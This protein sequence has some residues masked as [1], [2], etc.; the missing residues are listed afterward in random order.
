MRQLISLLLFILLSTTVFSQKITRD[1]YIR[2]WQLVAIE[3]MNR[4][5]IPASITMAQGCLESGNGNSELSR[6]SNNHFGIKCKSSWKGK[7]VY[8]DDDRRNE[9]FRSY[10]SVKD[11]YEDHTDFLMNNPRYASLFLLDHTDY[12]G[13]AKGLKKAGYATAHDYDKRLIRII[14][15]NKL[16][17]LDKKMTFT[18]MN[19]QTAHNVL[20]TDNKGELTITSFSSHTVSKIN[21]VKAVVAQKGDT[22]EILAQELG[23]KDWELYNFND[24]PAG[25]RPV[26]N[27]VVYIQPKKNKTQKDK[28]THRAQPG[29]TMHYISQLYGIKLKPL[30]RRN[31][32]KKGQQPKP[33]QVIY[34]HSKKK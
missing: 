32:M 1:A 33:G 22:Y 25:Y 9:C 7:K 27:E 29:E 18:P 3:E 2:Q 34:L 24:Q 16:H 28:L 20:D 23:L 19:G 10:R 8:Y 15:E 21:R 13:W 12:K 31:N 4:S 26:A 14:E 17:R 11:S 6:K 30:Y 5:G